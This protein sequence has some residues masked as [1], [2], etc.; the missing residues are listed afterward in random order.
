MT[1]IQGE[2]SGKAERP[3]ARHRSL[4]DG[5]IAFSEPG[6]AKAEMAAPASAK[7]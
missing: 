7:G 6:F 3:P 5:V 4:P 1:S 2:V